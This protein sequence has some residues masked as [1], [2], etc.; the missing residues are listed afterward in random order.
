MARSSIISWPSKACG[1]ALAKIIHPDTGKTALGDAEGWLEVYRDWKCD[2]ARATEMASIKLAKWAGTHLLSLYDCLALRNTQDQPSR[3]AKRCLPTRWTLPRPDDNGKHA[4]ESSYSRRSI[5]WVHRKKRGGNTFW[6]LYCR[7]RNVATSAAKRKA[8][9]IGWSALAYGSNP[10]HA[11]R[12][13]APGTPHSHAMT[14]QLGAKPE[15]KP[16]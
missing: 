5:A 14:S 7:G 2:C 15:T 8:G 3:L 4:N 12:I 11:S 1:K 10:V 9:W 6:D 13:P 16:S